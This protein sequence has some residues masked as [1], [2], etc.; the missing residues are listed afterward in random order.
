MPQAKIGFIGGTGLYEA[1]GL[2]DVE[3]ISVDT[4]FGKPSDDIVTGKLG[5]INIAFLPRHGKGHH[6]LPSAVPYRANI[7]ALKTLGVEYIIGIN[8]VGSLQEKYKPG[9]V[10]IPDQIID[11]TH[12]RVSTFFDDIVA[13]I[14]FGDPFCPIM[15]KLLYHAAQ[16]AGATAHK[17]GTYIAMEGPA[18]STRAESQ[19]YRT[20]G[21][22]VV[23]MTALP[24][25]KLAREA[26]IC[27]AIV[28]CITDYDSWREGHEAV[29]VEDILAILQKNE[30]VTRR[31]VKLIPG[32][33][34]KKRECDCGNALKTAIVTDPELIPKE[35]KTKLSILLDKYIS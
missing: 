21:A 4:P 30:E 17:G 31:M 25:A 24:E 7:F 12:N 20:W 14:S 8:S 33:L 2:T 11:R 19:L 15:Q 6:I 23:G 35:Y 22:D 10:L 32:R 1:E 3:E 9:D 13:H 16:G 26:G 34:P 28:A 5:G 27:Y 18:F 29:T